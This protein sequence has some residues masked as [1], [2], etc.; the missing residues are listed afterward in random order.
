MDS[1]VSVS[2]RSL[3]L[4]G[5]V[6][7]AL[8]TAYLLGGAGGTGATAR[9]AD[10]ET[11]AETHELTMTG[12]GDAS[13]VPDQLSFALAV[14]LTRPDLADALDAANRDMSRV[15]GSLKD[16]GVGKGDVQTTGLSMEPVYDYPSY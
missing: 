8:V 16:H 12:T 1:N 13:A 2:V 15:L 10:D 11:P 4:T 14:H 5:L 7:A 6:L 3:L 9:A